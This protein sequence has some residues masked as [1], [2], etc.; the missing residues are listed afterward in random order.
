MARRLA[1]YGSLGIICL[2]LLASGC[3]TQVD[4]A[5]EGVSSASVETTSPS[6]SMSPAPTSSTSGPTLI[7]ANVSTAELAFTNSVSHVDDPRRPE[8]KWA[9]PTSVIA[10]LKPSQRAGKFTVRPSMANSGGWSP[11]APMT[12]E[13]DPDLGW[14]TSLPNGWG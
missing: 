9:Q 11:L 5:A 2:S 14:Y 7:A 13:Y 6:S 12:I 4:R 8:L 10:G 1:S 3:A